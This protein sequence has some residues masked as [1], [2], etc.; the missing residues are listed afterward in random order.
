MRQ[1]AHQLGYYM[2]TRRFSSSQ[3]IMLSLLSWAP[4]ELGYS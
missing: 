2:V 1:A 3:A 4:G